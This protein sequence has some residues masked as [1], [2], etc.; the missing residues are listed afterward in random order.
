M[1]WRER[2]LAHDRLA[3]EGLAGDPDRG[4]RALD[5]V[6]GMAFESNQGRVRPPCVLLELARLIGER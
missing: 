1:E 5:T 4:G 6:G 2:V 3:R